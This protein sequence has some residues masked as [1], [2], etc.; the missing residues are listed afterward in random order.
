[1]GQPSMPEIRETTQLL[2]PKLATLSSRRGVRRVVGRI[3]HLRGMSMPSQLRQ[4]HLMAALPAAI[5][6]AVPHAVVPV[7]A[8]A[9]V[10]GLVT[11][12]TGTCFCMQETDAPGQ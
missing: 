8:S 12:I 7:I 5:G 2:Y 11:V 10:A 6:A 3:G 1:M 9:I 4:P